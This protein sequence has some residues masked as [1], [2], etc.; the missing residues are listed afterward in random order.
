[1][2]ALLVVLF[3]LSVLIPVF[4]HTVTIPDEAA[5]YKRLLI[6]SAQSELGLEAPTATLAAQIHQESLWKSDAVS[7][8]GAQG[9]AQFMPA[10]AKWMPEVDSDVWAPE[11]FNPAWSLLAQS[12]YMKWL[13]RRVRAPSDCD[14]WAKALSSYNGG[15]GWLRKD[16]KLAAKRGFDKYLWWDNVEVVNAGRSKSAWNENRH[17]PQ[18]ILMRWESAYEKDGWGEGVCE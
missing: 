17:Y 1:M 7:W 14:K 16:E 3:V 5:Q 2:K 4:G 10:T 12:A 13:L 8:V 15:L 9:L 11:P 6:R 18:R